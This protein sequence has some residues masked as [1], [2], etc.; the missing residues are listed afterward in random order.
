[1]NIIE[2]KGV[3]KRF[4][5]RTAP[6]LLSEHLRDRFRT[7]KS[8]RI[9]HALRDVS[10]DINRTEGVQIIGANGAGKSTL[11]SLITGLAEPDS[12]SISVRGRVGAL[13]EL[14]SG[15][16]PDLTGLENLT[17]NATLIG[18]EE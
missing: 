11:L 12:G 5:R 7:T 17:L 13:L 4:N 1:M 10:F 3:S 8:S 6:K 2:V 9:F 18:F 16:H 14:G 15:F